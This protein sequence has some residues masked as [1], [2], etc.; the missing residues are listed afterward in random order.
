MNNYQYK[1]SHKTDQLKVGKKGE[2]KRVEKQI[3]SKTRNSRCKSK[4]IS[5]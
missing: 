5:N 2:E 4:Y 3:E 1:W